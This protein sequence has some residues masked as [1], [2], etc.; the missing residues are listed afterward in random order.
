LLWPATFHT[1]L[2][3]VLEEDAPSRT[4]QPRVFSDTP[5]LL[6][7]VYIVRCVPSGFAALPLLMD[8]E[9]MVVE[10]KI[11]PS[12]K[13][14]AGHT[15]LLASGW[16]ARHDACRSAVRHRREGIGDKQCL[17]VLRQH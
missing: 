14:K 11:L 7:S 17:T 2:R 1:Y 6:Y 9:D 3:S 12:M 8:V 4:V 5:L 10:G 16:I 15:G 13:L